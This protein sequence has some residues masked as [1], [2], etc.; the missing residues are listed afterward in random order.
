MKRRSKRESI[1]E[2][3]KRGATHG[4]RAAAREALNRYDAAHPDEAVQYYHNGFSAKPK[5]EDYQPGVRMRWEHDRQAESANWQRQRDAEYARSSR[6]AAEDRQRE[7]NRQAARARHEQE[8][9]KTQQTRR[10]TEEAT[11]RASQQTPPKKQD[12]Y[13]YYEHID[14]DHTGVGYEHISRVHFDGMPLDY[15]APHERPSNGYAF[16]ALVVALG[17]LFI[18]AVTG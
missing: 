17:V 6:K 7:W 12:K 3:I 2:M 18:S 5:P 10:D 9:S 15:I 8:Y 11:K 1:I 16:L 13:G 4:E 14:H